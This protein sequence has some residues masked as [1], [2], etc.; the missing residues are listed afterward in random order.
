MSKHAIH[1]GKLI[2]ERWGKI[3]QPILLMFLKKC[4]I[5]ATIGYP[6]VITRGAFA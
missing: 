6:E 4:R 3:P 2:G 5:V 1:E